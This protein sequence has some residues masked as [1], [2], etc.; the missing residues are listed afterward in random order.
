MELVPN[1][2]TAD[3]LAPGESLYLVDS[4]VPIYEDFCSYGQRDGQAD[5]LPSFTVLFFLG[6]GETHAPSFESLGTFSQEKQTHEQRHI[7]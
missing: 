3:T 4:L 6:A 7:F 1:V 5:R 2:L